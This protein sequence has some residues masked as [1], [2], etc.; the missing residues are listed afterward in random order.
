MNFCVWNS[1]TANCEN[2]KIYVVIWIGMEVKLGK[3]C[4]RIVDMKENGSEKSTISR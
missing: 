4:V 2:R 3:L 1:G